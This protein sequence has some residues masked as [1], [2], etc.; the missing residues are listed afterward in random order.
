MEIYIIEGFKNQ[1]KFQQKLLKKKKDT[2]NQ[3]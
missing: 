2:K 1:N 3:G